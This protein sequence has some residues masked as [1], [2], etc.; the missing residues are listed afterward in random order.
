MVSSR[1][2]WT[3]SVLAAACLLSLAGCQREASHPVRGQT[4]VR[5]SGAAGKPP[6]EEKTQEWEI[7]PKPLIDH[8]AGVARALGA[9]PERVIAAAAVTEGDR[10]GGF[11]SLEPGSCL[12]AF[13]RGTSGIRDLDLLAYDDAG[14]P[15]AAD[16]ATD[17][18]PAILLCPPNPRRVFVSGRVAS[19]HGFVAIAAQSVPIRESLRVAKLFGAR[20]ASPD[21]IFAQAWPGLDGLIA[22]RHR[23][24]GGTWEDVR[25]AAIAVTPR[26]PVFVSAPLP[27]SRCLDVI[28]VPNE[29]TA[30]LEVVLSDDSGRELARAA[31]VGRERT[32]L[33]CSPV[34][35]EV[36]V[37]VRP[38]E[39]HGLVA[40][41]ISRS[42]PGDE[43]AL[44]ER[45]EATRIGPMT[46]IDKVRERVSSAL[47]RAGFDAKVDLGSGTARTGQTSM[48]AFDLPAGCSR[49]D[50]LSGAPVVGIRGALWDSKNELIGTTDGG[51]QAV[52][53]A[54][55]ATA[56]KA[57]LEIEGNGRPGPFVAE[58][59]TEK[60]PPPD[61]LHHPL[62]AC[63]LLAR[64]NAG[65]TIVSVPDLADVHRVDLDESRRVQVRRARCRG[66]LHAGHRRNA[67]GS[68]GAATHRGRPG[69]RGRTVDVAW[70]HLGVAE[71]LC[72]QPGDEGAPVRD[73]GSRA[74]RGSGGP[75]RGAREQAVASE[76]RRNARKSATRQGGRS[77]DGSRW[78]A[79]P[80]PAPQDA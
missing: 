41:I 17:P 19:G 49:I 65:G 72:A 6:C 67:A 26:A 79:P 34:D 42:E 66:H 64:A 18:K 20:I 56:Q 43:A 13:A 80:E 29:E 28:V 63:R 62:A 73:R 33:L 75:V 7:D 53:H 68:V 23:A 10:M 45:P 44:S 71:G 50:V 22:Q 37:S 31:N 51:E 69:E 77:A 27:G 78:P 59:R 30:N 3:R 74:S 48:I 25:K 9:G 24:L 60:A 2:R 12:L 46:P 76:S 1:M 54:C 58:L 39:G 5:K 8:D 11:V 21:Q 55:V 70:P 47:S 14:T 57:T 4:D 32:A 15:M 61:L 38:H 40:V 52:L 35:G 16:Q 36:T